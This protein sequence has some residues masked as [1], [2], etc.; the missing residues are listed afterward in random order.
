MTVISDLPLEIINMIFDHIHLCN[1][2]INILLT[3]RLWKNIFYSRSDYHIYEFIP[4]IF[5]DRLNKV[6]KCKNKNGCSLRP[7]VVNMIK[8]QFTSSK[9]IDN[10]FGVYYWKHSR[11]PIIYIGIN[12]NDEKFIILFE[13][14]A[15][16]KY[17]LWALGY[18]KLHYFGSRFIDNTTVKYE[19]IP[20]IQ[21][22]IDVIRKN[23]WILDRKE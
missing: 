22:I 13:Q 12:V 2:V 1:Q 14:S 19:K 23:K 20:F 7:R 5:T 4:L 15:L 18:D 6:R 17:D 8:E 21:D 9:L 10:I 3:C 11:R 16:P